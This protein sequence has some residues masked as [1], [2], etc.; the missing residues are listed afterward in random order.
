LGALVA[1]GPAARSAMPDLPALA[2]RDP[3][4]ASRAR[5][6]IAAIS[7]AGR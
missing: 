1:M 6:A 4:S 7:D 2:A 3:E 5:A